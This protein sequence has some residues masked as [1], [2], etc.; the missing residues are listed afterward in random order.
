MTLPD[1]TNCLTKA[2]S[3][4]RTML[5][6][7]DAVQTFLS[8]GDATSA[9]DRIFVDAEPLPA[10]R[11]V[12]TDAEW[13]LIQAAHLLVWTEP[14][15]GYTV[16]QVAQDG[17]D[18]TGVLWFQVKRSVTPQDEADQEYAGRTFKNTVGD[19]IEDLLAIT[20][21]LEIVLLTFSGPM[22]PEDSDQDHSESWIAAA[23]R[24]EWGLS[25]GEG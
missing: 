7:C 10:T 1:S 6:Q 2:E 13:A 8:A 18:A 21:P 15:D 12:Y 11:E 24:V 20:Y 16:S 5:S 9:L 17:H 25:G 22:I 19:I 3:D 23:V 14:E 4:L